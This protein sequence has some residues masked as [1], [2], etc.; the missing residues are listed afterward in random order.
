M[1]QK[2]NV[3]LGIYSVGILLMGVIGI[4][5]SLSAIA[6]RFPEYDMTMIQQLISIPCLVVIPA[7]LIAGKLMDFLA[8]KTLA[9]IGILIFIISGVLP[10]FLSSFVPILILRGIFGTAIAIV[11]VVCPA[12]VAEN[13][14][15]QERARTQGNVSSAQML[16]CIV[17]TFLGGWLGTNLGWNN[18]FYVHLFGII[19]L[20]GVIVFVPYK[21]PV[22][23][24]KVDSV[25][26]GESGKIKI[27]AA[28]WGWI[29]LIFVF[30]IG[31]QTYS[32]TVSFLVSDL[33]IGTATESGLSLAFFAF[34]GFI[35][36]LLFGK[37][38][39]AAKKLTL[40]IGL[41]ILT[42]SYLLMAFAGS[43]AVIYI[44]SVI[45][46]LAFSIALPCLIVG[47]A[48]SVD[49]R[50]ASMA[51][52][53]SA[54]SQNFAMFLCPTIVN[55]VAKAISTGAGANPNQVAL[56]WTSIMIGVLGIG[57]LIWGIHANK[58][59]LLVN[60]N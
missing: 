7:T 50:S 19:S 24:A 17:M 30:F 14:E 34:G 4:S 54:C 25:S 5:S 41:F 15:G 37:I 58:K 13:Y 60:V 32:N 59:D 36:G 52:S 16:G 38:T 48:N 12:L 40:C 57:M 49:A 6:A 29:I 44:G 55:P 56:I 9:I 27:T 42:V 31:G 39:A 33:K 23:A 43:M 3:K 28:A 47:A 21:K 51:V 1:E 46:G 18:V 2:K 53:I 8:K 35:M 22:K 20:I 11:S 10:A 26:E 45:C